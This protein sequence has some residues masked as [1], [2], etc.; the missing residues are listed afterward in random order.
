M[1]GWICHQF[2]RTFGTQACSKNEETRLPV[3]K[4][5]RDSLM[6]FNNFWS[7]TVAAQWDTTLS[8]VSV[9]PHNVHP[10]HCFF[11]PTLLTLTL[12]TM[13]LFG[14]SLLPLFLLSC[15]KARKVGVGKHMPRGAWVC[16]LNSPTSGASC[17]ASNLP[18]TL[19]LFLYHC[20]LETTGHTYCHTP[21]TTKH[22]HTLRKTK[23]LVHIFMVQHFIYTYKHVSTKSCM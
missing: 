1:D 10:F 6:L 13:L 20:S 4:P 9:F 8:L 7:Q 14:Q 15:Y 16:Q 3:S 17:W 11:P 2:G 21:T 23:A 18:S 5:F 19:L 22:T 12:L